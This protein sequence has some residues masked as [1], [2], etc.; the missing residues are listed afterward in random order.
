[1]RSRRL[2]LHSEAYRAD[3]FSPTPVPVPL[4]GLRRP[5][6]NPLQWKDDVLSA[7]SSHHPEDQPSAAVPTPAR[8]ATVAVDALGITVTAD[9]RIRGVV[10]EVAELFEMTPTDEHPDLLERVIVIG[11]TTAVTTAE[12]SATDTARMKLE[13]SA[14]RLVAAHERV[15]ERQDTRD[16]ALTERI[17]SHL[18]ALR[19]Q[20]ADNG[21]QETQ[22]R[23]QIKDGQTEVVKVAKQLDVSREE[24][25]KRAGAA[26]A[27]TVEAQ[28]KAKDEVIKGT[29]TALKKLMDKNDPTSA[30]ALITS[31]MDKAAADMRE[32]TG[33]NVS[34]LVNGL[35]KQFGE[36]SPLVEKIAKTVREG[37]EAEIKRV[38]EQ[39]EKLRS[40]LLEQRTRQQHKP[41][42]RGDSYEADLLELFSEGA[43]V[44][45]WTVDRTGATIGDNAGSKKGDHILT[46]ETDQKVAAIEARARGGIS[47]RLFYESAI[48]TAENRGVKIIIYCARNIDDLP[49]GLKAFSRGY[50]PFSYKCPD[51]VHVIATVIDPASETVVERLAVLLWLVDRMNR[52]RP[53]HASQSDAVDR[54][55]QAL[56]WVQQLADRLRSFRTIKSGLT[57]TSTELK[58]VVE[59]VTD[60]E[61]KL[62]ADLKM[63][64]QV[65]S[66]DHTADAKPNAA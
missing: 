54:I 26:I 8:T 46:D 36:N 52:Q 56:P 50:L 53:E 47:S 63:L 51:G 20:V 33:R 60:V 18:T 23:Q 48:S 38:E 24:L 27:M 6:P 44:Y 7:V 40:E 41:N 65:L 64:E 42:L 32:T 4:A 34:E 3:R 62:T 14:D 43:G 17:E 12:I 35:S 49:S 15:L 21:K 57:K 25:E 31:V 11:A 22:L 39:V 59:T 19:T 30:P 13:Q 58:R 5:T 45:G 55:A 1:M 16:K 2:I 61:T 28:T 66:G 29:E 10:K 9:L 37:A